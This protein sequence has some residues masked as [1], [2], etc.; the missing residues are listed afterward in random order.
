[1]RS[2]LI[3]IAVLS[4][5]SAA[6]H[7]QPSAPSRYQ[8]RVWW[9]ASV[10]MQII[11][12]KPPDAEVS[13]KDAAVVADDGLREKIASAGFTPRT[14]QTYNRANDWLG[15]GASVT[16]VDIVNVLGRWSSFQDWDTIGCL[17]EMNQLFDEAGN[18]VDGP[19]LERAW[20]RWDDVYSGTAVTPKSAEFRRTQLP[21]WLRTRDGVQ[22]DRTWGEVN[23]GDGTDPTA[24][25]SPQRRQFCI[26][27]GQAQ[28]WWHGQNVGLLPFT[29]KAMAASVGTTAAALDATPINPL[30]C[31]IVFDAL[32]RSQS[33]IIDKAVVD[34]RRAAYE[35]RDGSFDAERFG[36]DLAEAKRNIATSLAVFPGSL[37]VVFLI[38]FLQA[39]GIQ[40]AH[41]YFDNFAR[42]VG[43]NTQIWSDLLSGNGL[44]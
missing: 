44:P 15:M 7:A 13:N 8:K 37:N 16:D 1:M 24:C 5:A 18:L 31:E 2:I 3:M 36:A 20:G 21:V 14:A 11:D 19:A 22:R 4:V 17:E 12:G 34:E 25:Q 26:K 38:T 39:D 30:A 41:D 40:A 28:R 9:R 42:T 6:L 33:G 29:N 43:V 27:R 23:T 32:S 10:A 35:R